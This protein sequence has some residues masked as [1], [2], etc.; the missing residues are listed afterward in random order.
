LVWREHGSK[1]NSN[2]S[3]TANCVHMISAP[4]N[5]DLRCLKLIKLR[6]D[7]LLENSLWKYENPNFDKSL[8]SSK[9]IRTRKLRS[10]IQL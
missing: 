2:F 8:Q 9:K 1:P 4:A 5:K 3:V 7:P 6:F 10:D